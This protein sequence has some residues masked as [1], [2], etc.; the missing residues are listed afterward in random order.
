MALKLGIGFGL[1]L[2]IMCVLSLMA[3]SAMNKQKQAAELVTDAYIPELSVG[4]RF[5]RASHMAM[6]SMLRYQLTEKEEHISAAKNHLREMEEQGEAAQ[7]LLDAYPQLKTLASNLKQANEALGQ[8]TN[9]VDQT[10][11]IQKKIQQQRA[12][13]QKTG[14]EFFDVSK[15]LL[16]VWEQQLEQSVAAGASTD[17]I[18]RQ[19]RNTVSLNSVLDTCTQ[20]RLNNLQSQALQDPG[21][22]EQGL[23]LFKTMLLSLRDLER[24]MQ[25]SD[26]KQEITRLV[27]LAEAYREDLSD[28]L[29]TQQKIKELT[30]ARGR[31]GEQLAAN[32]ENTAHQALQNVQQVCEMT[33]DISEKSTGTLVTGMIVGVVLSLILAVLLTRGITVPLRKTV[34]YA[35]CV[36]EGGH[37]CPLDIRQKD[38]IG[39]LCDALGVMS[40][41]LAQRFREAQ[42]AI[43]KATAKEQEALAALNEAD[44]ARKQAEQAQRQGRLEAAGQ[45]ESVVESVSSA[46]EQLSAQVTQSEHGSQEQA[47]R[48]GETATAMEE[49]N[50]TVAEVAR[51]AEET[52][53]ISEEAKEKAQA[54]ANIVHQVIDGMKRLNSGAEELRADMTELNKQAESIGAIMNVI[55]DIA[56]RE[57]LLKDRYS[58]GLVLSKK[59]TL[60]YIMP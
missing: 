29:Q 17:D 31:Y 21:I 44:A 47:A 53:R 5:E 7:K 43:A 9:L 58:L 2:A 54:G 32:A 52:A 13:L 4:V 15:Q 38:E 49:M 39:H 51:N 45:L 22:A 6:S 1:V 56:D 57:F 8:Y 10:A 41:N 20:I 18:L 12:D 59:R 35:M 11:A 60:S 33:V 30:G 37:E 23:T 34:D 25:R 19:V 50:A 48:V 14:T 3:I 27:S 24:G 36:S 42:E 16:K 28:L 26:S 46:S 55:S 40:A